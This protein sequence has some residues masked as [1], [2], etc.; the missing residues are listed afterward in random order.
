[1]PHPIKVEIEVKG[2]VKEAF[3]ELHME[4]LCGLLNVT[5]EAIARDWFVAKVAQ[6][7]GVSEFEVSQWL[8]SVWG[9]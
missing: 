7:R 9:V 4:L 2:I 1:M 6:Y 8:S 3:T 5:D